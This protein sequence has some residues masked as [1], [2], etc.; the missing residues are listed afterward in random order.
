MMGRSKSSDKLLEIAFLTDKEVESLQADV[1]ALP[2]RP[3]NWCRGNR[4]VATRN[5]RDD[6]KA[7]DG[8]D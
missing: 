4:L 7:D 8:S 5:G 6:Q 2:S 1:E 3:D